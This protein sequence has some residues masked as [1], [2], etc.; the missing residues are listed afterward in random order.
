MN[1]KI[2]E[3]VDIFFSQ[4]HRELLINIRKSFS[5]IHPLIFFSLVIFLFPFILSQETKQLNQLMPGLI[6]ISALLAYLLS[7]E[8]FFEIDYENGSLESLLI[9]PFPLPLSVL[10][11]TL[12]HWF[13]TGLPLTVLAPIFGYLTGLTF[14]EIKILFLSLL[15]GTPALSCLGTILAAIT[16][17][18]GSRGLL[19]AI[20][21]IPLSIPVLIFGTGSVLAES[22]GLSSAAS[23]SFLAAISITLLLSTPFA[24]GAALRLNS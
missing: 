7:I 1:R 10:A 20:L 16:L 14:L 4:I 9:Y 22:M 21:L 13:L 18:L 8:R 24:A 15:V 11:K 17:S 3:S 19:L 12:T 5:I 2:F 23:L 6:W